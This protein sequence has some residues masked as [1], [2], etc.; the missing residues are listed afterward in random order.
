MRIPAPLKILYSILLVWS[1]N[2]LRAKTPENVFALRKVLDMLTSAIG[3]PKNFKLLLK[4]RLYFHYRAQ[5]NLY[6]AEILHEKILDWFAHILYR[7]NKDI[8]LERI[9]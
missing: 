2:T 7:K 9:L 5:C 4:L 8:Y 6:T 3:R 1:N